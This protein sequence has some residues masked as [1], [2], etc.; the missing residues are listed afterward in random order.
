MHKTGKKAMT[1]D[2]NSGGNGRGPT[3]HACKDQAL[4]FGAVVVLHT[5]TWQATSRD[6]Q[7]RGLAARTFTN[8][9]SMDAE[10]VIDL[11]VAFPQ[12]ALDRSR[13]LN[14]DMEVVDP[15]ASARGAALNAAAAGTMEEDEDVLLTE[16]IGQVI[17]D[18]QPPFDEQC[19]CA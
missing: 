14:S 17:C 4:L 6:A 1:S 16:E 2:S 19:E 13:S 10:D 7:Q 3:F 12:P 5:H 11:T 15:E 8:C 18:R 9:V